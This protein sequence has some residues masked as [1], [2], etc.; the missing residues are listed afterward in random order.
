MKTL[1][2]ISLLCSINI[3]AQQPNLLSNTKVATI[4]YSKKGDI[5]LYNVTRSI[6][7][8]KPNSTKVDKETSEN[9]KMELRVLEETDSTYTWEA[10]YFPIRTKMA[11]SEIERKL[12]SISTGNVIGYMTD[13]YGAYDSI[14]NL[15]FLKVEL[16]KNLEETKELAKRLTDANEAEVYQD[17]MEDLIEKFKEPSNVEAFFI[18]DISTIHSIY[19]IELTI[20]KPIEIDIWFPTIGDFTLTG[21]GKLNLMTLNKSTDQANISMSSRPNNDEL[22]AYFNSIVLFFQIDRTKKIDFENARIKLDNKQK[23][24]MSLTDGTMTSVEFSQ[25]S[26]ISDSKNKVKRVTKT[27]YEL[28]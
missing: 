17:L 8:F 2:F 4:G 27:V 28:Q 25:N 12:N 15:E 1:F 6:T 24:K 16:I 13:E 18:T 7:K 14:I 3:W 19:G 5:R 11:N 20:G 22:N 23:Y 26:T 10:R 9:Y 21:T